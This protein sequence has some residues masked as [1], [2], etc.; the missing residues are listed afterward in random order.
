[1]NTPIYVHAHAAP[2]PTPLTVSTTIRAAYTPT[3]PDL[4][5]PPLHNL[6]I[7]HHSD[8][9]DY[10]TEEEEDDDSSS[11]PSLSSS[12]SSIDHSESPPSL[13]THSRDELQ[14]LLESQQ[15]HRHKPPI[16]SSSI[17]H[18]VSRPKPPTGPLP[19]GK[20]A[21]STSYRPPTSRQLTL[22]ENRSSSSSLPPKLQSPTNKAASRLPSSPIIFAKSYQPL[23]S[24]HAGISKSKH[25]SQDVRSYFAPSPQRSSSSPSPPSFTPLAYIV[26]LASFYF[27]G[28]DL[29]GIHFIPHLDPRCQ[30]AISFLCSNKCDYAFTSSISTARLILGDL[31]AQ[32]ICELS[33]LVEASL[34]IFES[35]SEDSD[36]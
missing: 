13:K 5:C 14:T 3:N 22:I 1:M 16:V 17:F 24:P 33:P 30:P 4:P 7:L 31:Y 11:S 23:S 18:S 21:M 26:V 10:D 19:I 8:D 2:T 15:A 29:K 12:D 36:F 20:T 34:P 25:R 35:D 27:K 32:P 28:R 9:S 6:S